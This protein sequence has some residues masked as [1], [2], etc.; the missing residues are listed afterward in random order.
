MTTE[1]QGS[2]F[3]MMGLRLKE[4]VDLRRYE[5]LSGAPLSTKKIIKAKM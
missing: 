1:D 4:G 2:E 5:A 3:L